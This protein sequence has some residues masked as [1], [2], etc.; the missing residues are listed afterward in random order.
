MKKAKKV[1]KK[2]TSS[3]EYNMALLFALD[4]WN[5]KEMKAIRCKAYGG[6]NGKIRRPNWKLQKIKKQWMVKPFKQKHSQ[7]PWGDVY[8]EIEI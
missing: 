1:L 8:T 6:V 3:H 7:T 2:T 5:R 4:V